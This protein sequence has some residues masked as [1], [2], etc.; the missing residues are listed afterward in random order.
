MP[1]DPVPLVVDQPVRV[2]FAG[3]DDVVAQVTVAVEVA[4][5]RQLVREIVEVL[6]LL[7]L[8]ERRA[9]DCRVE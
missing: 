1:V 4:V 8:G 9:N 7:E 2:E 6:A 3:R 5:D